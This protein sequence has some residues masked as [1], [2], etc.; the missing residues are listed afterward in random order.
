MYNLNAKCSDVH[1]LSVLF[2]KV[3]DPWISVVNTG[4]SIC[5]LGVLQLLGLGIRS[6]VSN[7]TEIILVCSGILHDW[8]SFQFVAWTFISLL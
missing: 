5:V 7:G 4:R 8:S 6:A 1:S 2:P 3:D